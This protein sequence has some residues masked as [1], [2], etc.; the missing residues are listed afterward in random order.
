R[1]A[2]AAWDHGGAIAAMPVSDT[3]KHVTDRS[4]DHTVS[5]QHLWAAQTPQAFRLPALVEAF[6]WA[7]EHPA[8]YTD[9]AS[10]L[11][12]MG[13]SVAVVEGTTTNIKVTHPDDIALAAAL[14]AAR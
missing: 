10:I 11:E 6:A 8:A 4:I 7:A 9:E 13:R 2:Q 1:C 5:R 3:L 12:A 14:L